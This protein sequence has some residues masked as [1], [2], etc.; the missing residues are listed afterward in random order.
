MCQDSDQEKYIHV[1]FIFLR[2]RLA[3]YFV[4][5]WFGMVNFINTVQGYLTGATVPV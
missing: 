5:F 1:F 4:L 3:V 2:T